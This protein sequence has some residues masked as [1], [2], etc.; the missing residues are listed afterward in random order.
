MQAV[1]FFM[2]GLP[3]AYIG[4]LLVRH[5]AGFGEELEAGEEPTRTLPWQ[6]KPWADRVR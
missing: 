2:L 3:F 6:V 4:S 1:A 5:L